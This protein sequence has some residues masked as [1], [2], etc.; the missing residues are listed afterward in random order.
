MAAPFLFPTTPEHRFVRTRFN[1]FLRF[2]PGVNTVHT[3]F[4]IRSKHRYRSRLRPAALGTHG[5]LLPLIPRRSFLGSSALHRRSEAGREAGLRPGRRTP[6]LP[7]A[8]RGGGAAAHP[9]LPQRRTHGGLL[10]PGSHRLARPGGGFSTGPAP[11]SLGRAGRKPCAKAPEPT[12][13][14]PHTRSCGSPAAAGGCGKGPPRRR[15]WGGGGL[16]GR[17]PAVSGPYRAAPP[18]AVPSR[19]RGA[20]RRGAAE[21]P[22]GPA[23]HRSPRRRGGAAVGGRQ[24]L[25]S[26]GLPGEQVVGTGRRGREASGVTHPFLPHG[27]VGGVVGLPQR[28]RPRVEAAGQVA[29]PQK[30]L[31][32]ETPAS[33]FWQGLPSLGAA[34]VGRRVW[35]LHAESSAM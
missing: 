17:L 13:T 30:Q 9:A 5:R 24:C 16:P 18:T 33:G 34:Q 8:A 25:P 23:R 1:P 4:G 10:S 15:G 29:G 35:P 12:R 27:R 7:Q 14:V 11:A 22:A 21:P 31:H 2:L 6:S 28:L 20:Q 19:L 32:L 26:G 3:G